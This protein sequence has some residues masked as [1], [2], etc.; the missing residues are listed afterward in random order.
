MES[1]PQNP[2]FRI[3][4]EN[5]T[6]DSVTEHSPAPLASYLNLLASLSD[7]SRVKISPSLTGPLTFRMIDLLLS[8]RNSTLTCKQI[9]LRFR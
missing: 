1:Q 9:T 5:F 7:S 4:P 8:S 3:N 2:E 6:H